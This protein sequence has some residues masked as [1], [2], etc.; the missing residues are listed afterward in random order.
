MNQPA[1]SHSH[2]AHSHDAHSHAARVHAGHSTTDAAFTQQATTPVMDQTFWDERYRSAPQIWSGRPNPHLVSDTGALT[3]GRALDVGAGEGADAIWLATHGWK[4]TAVDISAV[5][6]ERGRAQAETLGADVQDNIT[7]TQADVLVADLPDAAFDLVTVQF[8]HFA[9]TD[10]TTFFRRCIAAV[11]PGGTL[12][13]AAHHP[14]DMNTTLPRPRVPDLY[15]SADELAE[16]LDDHWTIT[17]QDA[18][19]RLGHDGKGNKVTMHDTVL[20]AHRH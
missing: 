14:S 12:M 8:V 1:E 7:W 19:P 4:V 3:P 13:I 15:Y 6:L 9:S 20:V 10:R 2:D 16:L 18:R 11:A 17:A 5:A